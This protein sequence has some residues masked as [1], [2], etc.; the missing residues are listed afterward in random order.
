M[1]S[2]TIP[3]VWHRWVTISSKWVGDTLTGGLLI[4]YTLWF[5]VL[6]AFWDTYL[7]RIGGRPQA[8][9]NQG[10][11]RLKRAK[12]VKTFRGC[13]LACYLGTVCRAQPTTAALEQLATPNPT[14]TTRARSGGPGR[15]RGSKLGTPHP[16]AG[17]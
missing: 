7:G 8:S 3:L 6:C 5:L 12:G 9:C 13:G 1:P 4:E 11:L 16:N 2:E 10:G 17:V 14:G 15:A